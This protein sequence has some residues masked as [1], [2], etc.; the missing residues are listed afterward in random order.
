MKR[1]KR[2]LRVTLLMLTIICVTSKSPHLVEAHSGEVNGWQEKV[3]GYHNV[4]GTDYVAWFECDKKRSASAAFLW[5]TLG[6][7]ITL[8]PIQ[9]GR[10]I[11]DYIGFDY[12]YV[13]SS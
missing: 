5:F 8:Q 11:S 4:D 6:Y 12:Y 13:I 1:F 2:F 10:N 9:I 7:R 3:P